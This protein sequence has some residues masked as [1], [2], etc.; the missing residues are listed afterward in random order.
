MLRRGTGKNLRDLNLQL[1][2]KTGTT[3][4]N[5]DA[6][7]IGFTSNLVVGVYVG[8]DNPRSLGKF[9]TGSKTALPIFKEFVKNAVNNYEARPFKVA[10]GI[11]MMVVD[12]ST[13][14]KADINSKDTIIEAFKE[15]KIANKNKIGIDGLTDLS[16]NNIL[17]FY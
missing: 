4:K 10:K 3:N 14:K 9:E 7:F 11:K 12:P 17:K 13:G 15:E 16:Q 2:G 1:A 8:Y 5:T 6:W